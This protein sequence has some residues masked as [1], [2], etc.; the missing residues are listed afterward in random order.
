MAE[1]PYLLGLYEPEAYIFSVLPLCFGQE[2]GVFIFTLK[3]SS[4]LSLSEEISRISVPT[5]G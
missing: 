5:L 3:N 1:K 2:K 4:H